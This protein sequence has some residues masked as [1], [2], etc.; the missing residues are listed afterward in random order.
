MK[1]SKLGLLGLVAGAFVCGSA[2]MAGPLEDTITP[3]GPFMLVDVADQ[4]GALENTIT[5]VGPFTL[6]NV[7]DNDGP[8]DN[9][10]GIN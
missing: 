9:T 4:G 3:T 8:L 2:A 6:V 5:P 1:V 7:E 10:I